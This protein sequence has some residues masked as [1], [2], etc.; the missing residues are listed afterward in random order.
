MSKKLKQWMAD[1]VKVSLE[2]ADAAVLVGFERLGGEY[3]RSLREKLRAENV[4]LR[5]LRNRVS[6][7]AL[8]GTALEELGPLLKGPT[9]VVHGGD[10]PAAL[11]RAIVEGVKGEKGFE[12][13]GGIVEGKVV[14]AEEVK[15]LATLPSRDELLSM[16][17]SAVA[18]PMTNIALGVD[19]IM[20]GV[21]RAVDAVREKKENEA[22]A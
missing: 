4:K 14:G 16:I 1:E 8:K 13:R 17:A 6:E 21:A 11:A 5:V 7:N 20:T 2:D 22:A 19:A 9:A 10:D 3:S 15:Y 12:F 18:A